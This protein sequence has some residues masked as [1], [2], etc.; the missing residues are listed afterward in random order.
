MLV[1]FIITSPYLCTSLTTRP[2]TSSAF[3]TGQSTIRLVRLHDGEGAYKFSMGDSGEYYSVL[4]RVHA[5]YLLPLGYIAQQPRRALNLCR[6]DVVEERRGNSSRCMGKSKPIGHAPGSSGIVESVA[7]R[8]SV[9]KRTPM[10]A[11]SNMMW[12]KRD[13]VCI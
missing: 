8:S 5:D 4:V 1:G 2:D 6:R 9:K 7:V 13:R 3:R 11:H 10:T 12:L